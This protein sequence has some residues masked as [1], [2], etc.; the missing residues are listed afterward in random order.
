MQCSSSG[1]ARLDK[2]MLFFSWHAWKGANIPG[3]GLTKTADQD[4]ITLAHSVR[5]FRPA[6]CV[7]YTFENKKPAFIQTT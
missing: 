4:K 3:T 6:M 1:H 7:P 5:Q 2:H